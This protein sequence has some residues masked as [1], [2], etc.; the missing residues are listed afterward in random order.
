[1]ACGRMWKDG[2]TGFRLWTKAWSLNVRIDLLLI[3]SR[4]FKKQLQKVSDVLSTG[5]RAI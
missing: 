4:V 3:P 2:G 5:D 1:M